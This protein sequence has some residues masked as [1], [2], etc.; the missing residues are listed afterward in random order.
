MVLERVY[1]TTCAPA[2]GPFATS[3]TGGAVSPA[4]ATARRR[5]PGRGRRTRRG[6][7]RS[8]RSRRPGRAGRPRPPR[9]RSASPGRAQVEG[10]AC[11]SLCAASRRAPR[12]LGASAASSASAGAGVGGA[13][14]NIR[15]KCRYTSGVDR[16]TGD[17]GAPT[18]RCSRRHG[19]DDLAAA[20]AERGP[21]HERERHVA[22][23]L[24]RDRE[25]VLVGGV[26]SPEPV[27]RDQRGGGV[28]RPA[29]HAAGDGIDL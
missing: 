15:S 7:R 16:P 10:R 13:S 11:G 14:G 29:R 21:A 12:G 1:S 25:Q 22:A 2:T 6:R 23:Q 19:I 18:T 28:G 27:Q 5:L 4:D 3:T 9:R 20:G 26:H 24:G 17:S 8:A